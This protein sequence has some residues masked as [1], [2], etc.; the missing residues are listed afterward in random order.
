MKPPIGSTVLVCIGVAPGGADVLRP[1]TVTEAW[2]PVC[3][4]VQVLLDGTN[5]DRLIR[6]AHF[7]D[8]RRS[9]QL[10]VWATSLMEGDGIG[11]WRRTAS[12][13]EA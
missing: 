9:G 13:A 2:S 6:R 10:V 5:D 3:V 11:Q 1:A 4:N 7:L 8:R 12:P